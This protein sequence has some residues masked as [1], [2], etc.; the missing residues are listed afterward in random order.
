MRSSNFMRIL[1]KGHLLFIASTLSLSALAETRDLGDLLSK[2]PIQD[3]TENEKEILKDLSKRYP[4]SGMRPESCPLESK[5]YADIVAKIESIRGLFKDADCLNDPTI[6]DQ[7]T[8]EAQIVQQGLSEAAQTAGVDTTTITQLGS[9]VPVTVNGQQISSLLG[10]INNLFFKN[11]CGLK[12]GTIL[13]RSADVI[14]NFAQLGLLVPNS[15]G[16]IVSGGGLALSTL[17]RMV[18]NLLKSDFNFDENSDRQNFIKLNCAFYDLRHQIENSGMIDVATDAHRN[19]LKLIEEKLK[20]LSAKLE[21]NQKNVTELQK[22]I[23]EDKENYLNQNLGQMRDFL[24][25]LHVV[26]TSL[27]QSLAE[28]AS[29]PAQV[30][31]RQMILTLTK[32]RADLESGIDRYRERGLSVVEMFDIDFKQRLAQFNPSEN[33]EVFSQIVNM[34]VADFDRDVRSHLLFH[35]ER[36]LNDL[37][38]LDK[39]LSEQWGKETKIEGK[40]AQD[41]LKS[42]NEVLS[43][44]SGEVKKAHAILESFKSRLNRV[45]ESDTGFSLSDDGTENKTSIISSFDEITEQ[46]YGK[47]GYEFLKYTTTRSSETLGQFAES[48]KIF[49]RRHLENHSVPD[50]DSRTELERIFACQDSRPV[51]MRYALSDSLAQ[52]GH[53]F[54]QTNKD[55]FH[56]E[57]PRVFLGST[58]GRNGVH[59]IRS[60]F[61]VIQEQYKSAYVANRILKGQSVDPELR[62][63]FL[64]KRAKRKN[65]LGQVMLNVHQRKADAQKL[66][67]LTEKFNCHQLKSTNY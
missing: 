23:T 22:A 9:N 8:S 29:R 56:A 26:K 1:R 28:N 58:G 49:D 66:Q 4:V 19:D 55:L 52:Q 11:K 12:Q 30:E 25:N 62:E 59:A 48:Y 57:I 7:I 40:S 42:V 15:N 64:G 61:E 47:W 63:K 41:Y 34:K 31:Q 43:K 2:Y 20:I 54:V 44:R 10:N 5:N 67:T 33:P 17:L 37:T 51:R 32:M 45:V 38:D 6:L 46:I 21:S 53:D 27:S 3:V 35:V 36:L 39:K 16:L 13:E 18:D 14:Q 60:K 65:Y 24:K 50:A